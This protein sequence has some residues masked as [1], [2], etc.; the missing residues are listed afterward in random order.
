MLAYNVKISRHMLD[1]IPF[2]PKNSYQQT[3]NNNKIIVNGSTKFSLQFQ[4][5]RD[6][7]HI[8]HDYSISSY[9]FVFFK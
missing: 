1:S 7:S 4:A 6:D 9:F 5:Q 3:Q 8:I 2:K